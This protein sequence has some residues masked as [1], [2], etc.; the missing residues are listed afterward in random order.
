MKKHGLTENLACY[1]ALCIA[2]T[3]E[4]VPAEEAS[5]VVYF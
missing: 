1:V 2:M 4:D 3:R 5:V